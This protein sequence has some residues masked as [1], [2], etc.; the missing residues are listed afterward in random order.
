MFS[1][2]QRLATTGIL[3]A[4]LVGCAASTG[5]PTAS[6]TPSTSPTPV[7]TPTAS[8][9][10]TSAPEPTPRP[11]SEPTGPAVA[12]PPGI[13]PPGSVAVVTADGLRVR[14]GGPGTPEHDEVTYTLN[15]GDVVLVGT[16]PSGSGSVFGYVSPEESADGRGWYEIHVGGNGP[17]SWIDGGV[18]G[19]IS[20]GEDG[21][22]YLE[23]L[24][25][26]CSAGDDLERVLYRV[27]PVPDADEVLTAW[28]RLA[29]FGD[30]QLVLEGIWEYLCYEGPMTPFTFEPSHIAVPFDCLGIVPDDIDDDGYSRR[31]GALPL[32]MSDELLENAPQRGDLITVR[33]H[34]DDPLAATCAASAPEEFDGVMPDT[35]FLVLY[36]REQFV[37][38]EI[39]VTGHRDLAP[40]WW[41]Q[42]FD[43]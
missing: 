21:L 33:G 14:A 43:E 3:A 10:S 39:T 37:V 9:S 11:S 4:V 19:W 40:P 38:E 16:N 12:P 18:S 27:G 29:C 30:R 2:A 23:V 6:V 28:D 35:E 15:A 7:P 1:H 25:R 13:L 8:I 31:A 17:T 42:P 36:C 26:M 24:P 22:E 41:E 32:R 20:E 34:F 5:N